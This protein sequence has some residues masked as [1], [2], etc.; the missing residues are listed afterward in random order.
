MKVTQAEFIRAILDPDLA[1][2]D[3]LV[4]P[5]GHPASERFNVYRNNVAVSLTEALQTTF[6][7]LVSALGEDFFKAMAGVFLRKH[8]PQS[9]LLMHYGDQMPN[10]LESFEPVQKYFYLP[11]IAKLEIALV[12]SYHAAD[13]QPITPTFLEK[14]PPEELM[15]S[16]FSL[17]PSMRLIRSSWPIYQLW[18]YNTVPNS[19]SPTPGP[20]D[21]LVLRP[22]F[23]PSP[24]LLPPGGGAFIDAILNN[25]TLDNATNHALNEDKNHDLALTL[26]MLIQGNA[27]TAVIKGK[28]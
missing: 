24:Q 3:G 18:R 8:P 11:D 1:A 14:I 2:P 26:G 21:V 5:E 27:I 4:T 10:F 6:P 7:L 28:L 16:T 9:P 17:A 12:Q 25:L 20:E 23:D 13:S 19:P 22:E 15:E